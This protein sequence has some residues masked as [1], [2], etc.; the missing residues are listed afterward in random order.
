MKGEDRHLLKRGNRF[1]YVRGVPTGLHHL[2]SRAPMVR[3]SLKT[4]SVHTARLLRDVREQADDDLWDALRAGIDAATARDR[5]DAAIRLNSA[6]GFR[7]MTADEMRADFNDPKY[8]G[9]GGSIVTMPEIMRRPLEATRAGVN[10]A[11][12][13]AVQD[14]LAADVP[15]PAIKVSEAIEN[16]IAD[17]MANDWRSKSEGQQTRSANPKRLAA[18]VFIRVVGDLALDDIDRDDALKFFDHFK[19]RMGR[20]EVGHSIANRCLDNLRGLLRWHFKRAGDFDRR[21]PFD[22]LSFKGPRHEK[23][24]IGFTPEF[25]RA[26]MLHGGKLANLNAEARRALLIIMGTGCRPSEVL[27]LTAANIKLDVTVPHVQIRDRADRELKTAQSERDVPL[28]GL[29]LAAMRA[30]VAAGNAEGFPRYLDKESGFSATVNKYL[31]ENGLRETPEHTLY[32]MRHMFEDL[33]KDADIGDEMRR[34]LM[35]HKI[36]RSL[37]GRGFA[38][39]AKAAALEKA[40]EKLTFDPAVI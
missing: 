2:D 28:T 21:N 34:E 11:E 4:K 39:E 29:A 25:V 40:F 22:R 27:N 26:N 15:R 13:A 36:D 3:L 38:L 10:V 5:Y 32:S 35:G 33:L 8:F 18:E 17:L 6:L 24:R 7:R 12:S 16:Q 19:R 1:H 31:A 30:H 20:G 14:A 9:P 23:R 37:Y